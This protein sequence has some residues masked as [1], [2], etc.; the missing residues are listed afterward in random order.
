MPSVRALCAGAVLVLSAANSKAAAAAPSG[1]AGPPA[2][3]IAPAPAGADMSVPQPL[4][5]LRTNAAVAAVLWSGSLPEATDGLRAFVD[6]RN[7]GALSQAVDKLRQ[8]MRGRVGFDPLDA[9]ALAK[10]GLSARRGIGVVQ[11]AGHPQLLLAVA[12]DDAA[13]WERALLA[14]LVEEEGAGALQVAHTARRRPYRSLRRRYG[15]TLRAAG[16]EA[17]L[18]TGWAVVAPPGAEAAL[19]A[20][21]DADGRT[22]PPMGPLTLGESWTLWRRQPGLGTV[23]AQLAFHGDE[24]LT[25]ATLRPSTPL[26]S[27]PAAPKLGPQLGEATPGTVLADVYVADVHPYLARLDADGAQAALRKAHAALPQQP[28][29]QAAAR[30][31]AGVQALLSGPALAPVR[32]ILRDVQAAGWLRLYPG[33]GGGKPFA[34]AGALRIDDPNASAQMAR[35]FRRRC[36]QPGRPKPAPACQPVQQ[37]PRG[38]AQVVAL[39]EP[40]GASA[41][42]LLWAP[43]F[44]LLADA[45]PTLARLAEDLP[46]ATAPAVGLAQ[47]QV[48]ADAFPAAVAQAAVVPQASG[49]FA[50]DVAADVLTRALLPP[51]AQGLAAGGLLPKLLMAGPL[52]EAMREL[53]ALGQLDWRLREDDGNVYWTGRLRAPR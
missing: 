3:A 20:L 25:F 21:V 32:G 16:A 8:S 34:V 17:S 48:A 4:A 11:V 1:D 45:A 26:G 44:L 46:S 30:A 27:G 7:Q 9:A 41:G 36:G 49:S 29:A 22:A 50:F 40:G 47:P 15:A 5:S 53:A 52:G 2:P 28:A 39:G 37:T 13:A 31:A 43:P 10:A 18:G 19:L 42:Q 24:V 12:V 51:A 35:Y 6:A 38:A 14:G 23:T 33:A